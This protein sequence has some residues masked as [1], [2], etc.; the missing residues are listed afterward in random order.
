[1][2]SH[3]GTQ[4]PEEPPVKRQ[5]SA[6][7]SELAENAAHSNCCSLPA[8]G[9]ATAVQ[10]CQAEEQQQVGETRKDHYETSYQQ[11][12]QQQGEQQAQAQPGEQQQRQQ[13]ADH[14]QQQQ[15]QAHTPVSFACSED[16]GCR[17]VMEDVW[18]AEG[19]ARGDKST[20]LRWARDQLLFV[21]SVCS[22]FH[23]WACCNV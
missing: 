10:A 18:V 6:A 22:A 12:Q 13:Q 2:D 7:Q 9:T 15:Q 19:D 17:Q 16:K 5:K 4:Q 11:Q 21:F 14:Q 3:E 1:M 20:P 8:S 23:T